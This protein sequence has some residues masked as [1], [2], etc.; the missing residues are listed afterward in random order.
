MDLIMQIVNWIGVIY[1]GIPLLALFVAFVYF[2]FGGKISQPTLDKVI[3]ISKWYIVSVA[4]VFAAKTI[5]SGFSERETGIREMEVYDKYVSTILAADNI[6]ARW[7]LAQ[8]F[9][10]VTPT[11][12]LRDRW[13]NYKTEITPDYNNFKKLEEQES[14]LLSKGELSKED[15]QELN[16]IQQEKATFERSLVDSRVGRYVIVFTGDTNLNLAKHEIE[17][18]KKAGIDDTKIYF[19][20]NS[21]RTISKSFAD[22]SDAAAYMKKYKDKLRP[23]VYI[24]DLDK[25]CAKDTYNDEGFYSCE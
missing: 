8:Y 4:I 16:S 2:L 11:Q 21:Y 10:T 6:E 19:R 18:L 5:E 25:W 3:D 15:Q 14:K 7:K 17:K 9:S 1:I 22:R 24:V 23:D 13:I 12:R 20:R